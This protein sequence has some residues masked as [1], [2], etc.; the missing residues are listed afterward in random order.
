RHPGAVR[1]KGP[2]VRRFV[3]PEQLGVEPEALGRKEM[4][5][6]AAAILIRVAELSAHPRS[7]AIQQP[8]FR[9]DKKTRRDLRAVI[10]GGCN[11][12]RSVGFEIIQPTHEVLS[13]DR[14]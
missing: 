11:W 9:L 10:E 5:L 6:D 12:Q 13:V 8:L 14:H 1:S 4:P 7:A 2:A 3:D